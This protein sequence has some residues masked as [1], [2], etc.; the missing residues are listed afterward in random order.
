MSSH[1]GTLKL[2]PINRNSKKLL[3]LISIFSI[4]VALRLYLLGDIPPG[5]YS[6]EVS[7]FLNSKV[8]FYHITGLAFSS[9]APVQ[10]YIYSWLNGYFASLLIFGSTP[11]SMRFP[12]ALFG[13]L[14]IFPLYYLTFDLFKS[15]R[16]AA[17]ASLFWAISPVAIITSRT[18]SGVQLF[19]LFLFLLAY[20]LIYK[21]VI[22]KKYFLTIPLTIVI[23]LSN[24]VLETIVWSAIPF[25]VTIFSFATVIIFRSIRRTKGNLINFETLSYLLF[26]GGS[27]LLVINNAKYILKDALPKYFNGFP[28]LY[29]YSIFSLNSHVAISQF[30]IRYGFFLDPTKI[31]FV[32]ML[33]SF[34]SDYL[35]VPMLYF[36]Q[37]PL[38]FIGVAYLLFL[39]YKRVYLTEAILILLPLAAGFIWPVINISVPSNEPEMAEAIFAL[40]FILIVSAFFLSSVYEFARA[41]KSIMRWNSWR[42]SN[43]LSLIP[44]KKRMDLVRKA[45]ATFIL[46]VVI[47]GSVNTIAFLGT[48][49][50]KAAVFY[51]NDQNYYSSPFYGWYRTSQFIVSKHLYG[52]TIYF[53]PSKDG[54]LNLTNINDFRYW[55]GYEHYPLYWLY[56]F[57]NGKIRNINALLPPNIPSIPS[58]VIAQNASYLSFLTNCGFTYSVLK[59][60]VRPNGQPAEIILQ[61]TGASRS[62]MKPVVNS[63]VT[64]W[65]SSASVTKNAL[66]L[67]NYMNESKSF[68]I[69]VQMSFPQVPANNSSSNIAGASQ[70]DFRTV[71]LWYMS[72]TSGTDWNSTMHIQLIVLNKQ[73][74]QFNYANMLNKNEEY[75]IAIT[76]LNG[77]VTFYVNGLP[78][79][80]TFVGNNS[81][82][83]NPLAITDNYNV[84]NI[85]VWNASIPG[86]AIDYLYYNQSLLYQLK[87]NVSANP[88]SQLQTIKNSFVTYWNSSATVTKNALYLPNYMNQSSR[89]TVMIQTRSI[90]IPAINISFNT[91]STNSI[92][93]RIVP[94]GPSRGPKPSNVYLFCENQYLAGYSYF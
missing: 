84:E 67:P 62:A 78:Y 86:A 47:L 4:A 26:I 44:D 69:M 43:R 42:P 46:V 25:V 3:S 7:F 36:F 88:M 5:V 73:M 24:S 92:D 75:Q 41:K 55:F 71:P 68:T 48:Y 20:H 40:P 6:D 51:A 74:Y 76:Y 22:E 8:I 94:W 85:Y 39:N 89:L 31:S 93:F 34:P 17:M 23:Y 1:F 9:N 79:G 29:N 91:V 63:F 53:A 56:T 87:S 83:I 28:N 61:M 27:V 14:I 54:Y 52:E 11:F 33:P 32:G 21:I 59:T 60:V 65:N 35:S 45:S 50:T 70:I 81:L 15:N 2:S 18:G 12:S 49:Y 58:I 19:P 66:Y 13:S 37:L 72:G 80:E 90:Q 82:Q 57:S 77:N 64:Y 10:G 38:F 30:F 16:I